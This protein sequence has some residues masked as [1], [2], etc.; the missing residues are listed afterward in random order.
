MVDITATV[1]SDFRGYYPEFSDSGVWPDATLTRHLEDAD[2][3]TGS[4]RWGSYGSGPPSFK[5]RGLFAYAAHRA[6]VAKAAADAVSSGGVP[7]A[8]VQAESKQVGDESV[9]YAV[10]RPDSGARADTVGGLAAT[11]Y[12][13]EF[14]RLRKRAGTGAATTGAISL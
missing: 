11:V 5:A 3:E 1:I 10:H 14:L 6:V 13:Q 4:G 7:S 8:T 12:G 2:E 9:T